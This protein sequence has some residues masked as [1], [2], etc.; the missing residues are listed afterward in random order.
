VHG[1]GKLARQAG[2]A[3]YGA[4]LNWLVHG[5]ATLTFP[6]T[7][8]I[9][10]A[11][12]EPDER[13]Q[14][15]VAEDYKIWF[16]ARLRMAEQTLSA[17]REYLLESGFSNADISVGYAIQLALTLGMRADLPP[18]C[19]AWFERLSKREG[20]L[21]AKAAQA[22]KMKAEGLEATVL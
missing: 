13:K 16:L 3:D 11:L 1:N 15:S 18:R 7:I 12:R 6:Q 10:Y 21:R 17:G 19:L 22:A 20:F 2:D 4:Y 8:Y 5:E 9:R 14:P